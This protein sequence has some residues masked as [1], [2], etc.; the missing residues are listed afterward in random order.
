M[1]SWTVFGI[2][3]DSVVSQQ[4]FRDYMSDTY[5]GLDTKE[6]TSNKANETFLRVPGYRHEENE[7]ELLQD[8]LLS[9][10]PDGVEN[11]RFLIVL[12]AN[13]TSDAADCYFY[14]PK[15]E[16]DGSGKLHKASKFLGVESDRGQTIQENV[17]DAYGIKVP[18][19]F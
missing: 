16:P 4:K 15:L 1:S 14:K 11:I 9:V 13:N 17:F 3:S 12:K 5:V 18:T 19:G 2:K 10:Y 7:Y 8:F 6:L